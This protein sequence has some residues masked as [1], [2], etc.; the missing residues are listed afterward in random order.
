MTCQPRPVDLVLLDLLSPARELAP[1]E[2]D[3]MNDEAWREIAVIVA[4]HRLAPMLYWIAQKHRPSLPLPKDVMAGWKEAFSRAGFRVLQA[5][6]E[7]VIIHRLLGTAGIPY[8]ALKGAYLAF[9]A[10]PQAGLRPMRDVDILVPHEHAIEAYQLLLD[11]GAKR[12]DRYQG[13]PE[14]ALTIG[15]HHLPPIVSSNGEITLEVHSHLFHDEGPG[16]RPDLAADSG[17]WERGIVQEVGGEMVR[18][19][20][21]ADQ[22]L[23]LIVHAVYDHQFNNG[24]LLISDLAYLIDRHPIDWPAFWQLAERMGRT[25]GALLALLF[26]EAC[27]GSKGVDYRAAADVPAELPADLF[28]ATAAL[29]TVRDFEGRREVYRGQELGLRGSLRQIPAFI[30]ARLLRPRVEVAAMYPI[31]P[32][33]PRIFLYYLLMWK[34]L[35][36]RSAPKYIGV[37]HKPDVQHMMHMIG[38][39]REWLA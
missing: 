39:V 33:S 14:A 36:T 27:W 37:M 9:H 8:I 1:S 10:Y 23:H 38:K 25:R 22:L 31:D 28:N 21:P 18:F 17:F 6:R 5:Q 7:L 32:R 12:I 2:I 11:H 35:L 26:M 4:K 19:P 30:A 16:G 13:N 24:P 29:M 3:S 20:A 34:R 15:H